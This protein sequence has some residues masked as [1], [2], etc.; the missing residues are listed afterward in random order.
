MG[1]NMHRLLLSK[2]LVLVK[3]NKFRKRKF[4]EIYIKKKEKKNENKTKEISENFLCS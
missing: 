4:T 1:L 2:F 3:S